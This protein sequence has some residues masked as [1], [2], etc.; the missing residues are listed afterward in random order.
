MPSPMS[1]SR[2]GLRPS[3]DASPDAFG[4]GCFLVGLLGN[5]VLGG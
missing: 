2:C 4:I 1:L 3:G 5:G